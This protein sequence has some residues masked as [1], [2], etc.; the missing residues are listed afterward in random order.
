[1]HQ[2]RDASFDW[3]T[4][5]AASSTFR[6]F[7][8]TASNFPRFVANP[9]TVHSCAALDVSW[10]GCGVF[11][12]RGVC[13]GGSIRFAGRATSRCQSSSADLSVDSDGM[14]C[15]QLVNSSDTFVGAF[16][17][18]PVARAAQDFEAAFRGDVVAGVP[19]RL[20]S[21]ALSPSL[22]MKGRHRCRAVKRKAD[23]LADGS[24]PI[25]RCSQ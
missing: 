11:T 15:N 16:V 25:Q 22:Q 23:S 14:F 21:S 13:I 7:P 4:D 1:M 12:V 20:L 5:T 9:R 19:C 2:S 24:I 8:L 3:R 18:D 6:N 10:I 17:R